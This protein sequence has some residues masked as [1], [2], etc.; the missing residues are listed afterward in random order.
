MN[1][2]ISVISL[3]YFSTAAIG[4]MSLNHLSITNPRPYFYFQSYPLCCFQ[5]RSSSWFQGSRWEI[6]KSKDCSTSAIHDP[7]K[8]TDFERIWRPWCLSR[9]EVATLFYPT[10]VR[11]HKHLSSLPQQMTLHVQKITTLFLPSLQ[12]VIKPKLNITVQ[13][14]IFSYVNRSTR[15]INGAIWFE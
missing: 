15:E 13:I 4:E 1:C 5:I 12:G 7:S 2:N 14:I 8:A 11:H 9:R 3:A 10:P 6:K